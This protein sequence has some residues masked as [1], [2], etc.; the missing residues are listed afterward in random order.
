MS[1]RSGPRHQRCP[2][3]RVA[4]SI[5]ERRAE[6]RRIRIGRRNN[7]QVEVL[8]GLKPGERVITSD[9]TGYEKVEQ[10]VLTH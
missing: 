7:E 2:P 4:T 10:V 8:A 5:F 6:K 9:Y 1:R 3:N